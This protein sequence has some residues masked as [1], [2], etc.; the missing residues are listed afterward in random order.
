M[1]PTDIE[2]PFT[3]TAGTSFLP[4]C[5][6]ITKWCFLEVQKSLF[7]L[8]VRFHQAYFPSTMYS[9]YEYAM[10]FSFHVHNE[11][12]LCHCNPGF[13]MQWTQ[14]K[15]TQTIK[16]TEEEMVL[17]KQKKLRVLHRFFHVNF[18]LKLV[19][20][21]DFHPKWGTSCLKNIFSLK[22]QV[23]L[24]KTKLK[25]EFKDFLK[26]QT[27]QAN[28]EPRSPYRSPYSS[29]GIYGSHHWPDWI[30]IWSLSGRITSQQ[31]RTDQEV[32]D[33]LIMGQHFYSEDRRDF[34]IPLKDLIQ[35][36]HK[37]IWINNYIK[38]KTEA[39]SMASSPL[40]ELILMFCP[41]AK[42]RAEGY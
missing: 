6:A 12:F 3:Y 35:Q 38:S 39:Y 20:P 15:G 17:Q 30:L 5:S 37:S 40:P 22:L 18:I 29:G 13:C 19:T 2:K 26:K 31:L 28:Q 36:N 27:N 24:E 32:N 7:F 4:V 1:F 23:D 16:I 10:H 42:Q 34:S 9:H 14:D 8:H 25:P 33:W 41:K 11:C 21:T